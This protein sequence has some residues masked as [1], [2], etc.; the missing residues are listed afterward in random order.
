[1]TLGALIDLYLARR[2]IGRLRTAPSVVRVLRRALEPLTAMHAADVRRRDL[3]ASSRDDCGS[4][5]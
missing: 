1:M 5:P 4:R 3:W 2:V